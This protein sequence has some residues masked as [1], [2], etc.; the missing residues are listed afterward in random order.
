MVNIMMANYEGCD[1]NMCVVTAIVVAKATNI[2]PSNKTSAKHMIVTEMW[3]PLAECNSDICRTVV[4]SL[5]ARLQISR[6]NAMSHGVT[7]EPLHACERHG[8]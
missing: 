4:L 6:R 5:I 3:Q 2:C 7:H 8:Q 1:M